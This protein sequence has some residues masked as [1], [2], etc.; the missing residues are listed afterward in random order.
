MRQTLPLGA[1]LALLRPR[2]GPGAQPTSAA[3]HL[4]YRQRPLVGVLRDDPVAAERLCRMLGD[5]ML[6]GRYIDRLPDLLPELGDD[7]R[8]GL[9]AD[10]D[11]LKAEVNGATALRSTWDQKLDGL[12]RFVRR[13]PLRV[14]ARDLL[15]LADEDEVGTELSSI[16]DAATEAAL[17]LSRDRSSSATRRRCS[18]P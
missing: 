6:V 12:R 17:G 11:A 14:A 9:A 1:R 16:A 7:R 15:G 10:I 2:P 13:H 8:L 18:S 5:S 3:G 4:H